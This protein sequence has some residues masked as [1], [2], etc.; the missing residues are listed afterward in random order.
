MLFKRAFHKTKN[1]L[2]KKGG[3]LRG[4]FNDEDLGPQLLFCTTFIG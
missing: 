3:K 4:S 2:R 1:P